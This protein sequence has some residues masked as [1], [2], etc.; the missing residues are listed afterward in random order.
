MLKRESL[1]DFPDLPSREQDLEI[2]NKLKTSEKTEKKAKKS[3]TI[4]SKL[5]NV[6]S[7]VQEHLGK[8]RAKVS[9]VRTKSEL[10]SFLLLCENNGIVAIDT[11]TTGL[12]PLTDKVVGVC[13]Y[14]P[15]TTARYI[16]LLHKVSQ[17]TDELVPNQFTVEE[18][19]DAFNRLKE[20]KCVFH[21]AKFDIEMIHT[22]F[23]V[24]IICYWD[25]M[26]GAKLID[27]NESAA[28][29]YQYATHIEGHSKEYDFESLFKSV[30][31]RLVSVDTATL[32]AATDALITYELYEYQLNMLSQ[33][34]NEKVLWLLHNIEIP[35]IDVIACMEL[36][37]V[38]IDKSYTDDLEK[39]YVEKETEAYSEL[40]SE[41][42]R[43]KDLIDAYKV[44]NPDNKLSDPINFGSPSQLATLLYDILKVSVVDKEQPR[45][46]GIDIIKELA[47]MYPDYGFLTTLLKY[48]TIEKMLSTYIRKMP[49]TAS[50]VDGRVHGKF[51]Q[52]GAAT[53]RFSS[54]D[55]N[56]QNIPVRGEGKQIRK[57]F[58]ASKGYKLVGGDYS[59]QEPR[60]LTHITQDPGFLAAYANNK[61]VYSE[62]ASLVNKLPYEYCLEFYPNGTKLYKTE[63]GHYLRAD[64][65]TPEDKIIVAGD[66]KDSEGKVVRYEQSDGKKRR[67][68]IKAIVLGIMYSKGIPSTAI[69]LK[70]SEEETKNLFDTFFAEF[71]KVR[72]FMDIAQEQ[73]RR[74]G[75]VQ[76]IWGRKRHLPDMQL[77]PYELTYEKISD[78]PFLEDLEVGWP[79]DD[80]TKRAYERKLE[81]LSSYSKKS[82]REALIEELSRTYGIKVRQNGGFISRAKRQCVNSVIQGSAA[83]LTKLAMIKI[84]NNKELKDLGFRLLLTVHDEIIGEAPEENADKCAVILSQVMMNAG[85]SD[86]TV[87][88]KVDPEVSEIWDW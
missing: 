36:T 15:G 60:L 38:A 56:L 7:S 1:F 51:N 2:V 26:V 61:D 86:I 67:K 39:Q 46:T 75:C 21:N 47:K 76:T 27:E 62:V 73:A 87:P 13:L 4:A 22:N 11:E 33:P 53:G 41:L 55:P 29:K 35:I 65:N 84:H 59:Q 48:R 52:Y 66:E 85:G 50:E 54:S 49:A 24:H 44:N 42:D 57:L 58:V 43:L 9:L 79:I 19:T 81:S 20:L 30:D 45:G 80:A 37:G 8:Y 63:D 6:D 40:L 31:Y 88:M 68:A 34:N 69:D 78:T 71:P 17:F 83:D 18:M 12:D 5:Q 28:L 74:D 16:P 32:Y 14:T 10:E 64:E 70:I 82:E 3:N 23:N 77:P 72:E 25:T